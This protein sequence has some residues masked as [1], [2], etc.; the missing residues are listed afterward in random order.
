[1]A[2]T[3]STRGTTRVKRVTVGKPVRKINEAIADVRN[4]RG[5]DVSAAEE[6]STLV[7]NPD[8]ETFEA[9][10]NLENTNINGGQY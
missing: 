5:L 6:G 4:I 1:M 3:V 2:T 8:T 10:K 7:Y 9:V